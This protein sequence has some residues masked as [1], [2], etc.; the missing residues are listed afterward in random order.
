MR[1]TEP[2]IVKAAKGWHLKFTVNG[3]VKRMFFKDL[4]LNR[5]KDLGERETAFNIVREQISQELKS[6]KNQST[7]APKPTYALDNSLGDDW[8]LSYALDFALEKKREK[9][10][11]K[12]YHDYKGTIKYVQTAIV[13]LKYQKLP[14]KETTRKHI[15]FIMEQVKK[16]RQWSDYAYN[17]NLGYLQGVMSALVKW[18]IIESNPA[19]DQETYKIEKKI[20][21]TATPEQHRQIAIYLKEIDFKFYRYVLTLFHTGIRP[22][23]LCDLKLGDINM[24]KREITLKAQYTKTDAD[25]VVAISPE[26]YEHLY[27][28]DFNDFPSTFYLFGSFCSGKRAYSNV[29]T[30]APYRMA[31]SSAT[32]KWHKYV[33]TDLGIQVDLYSNKH[34]GA[35]KLRKLGVSRDAIKRNF[36]HGSMDMTDIYITEEV[37][38]D[39]IKR[40]DLRFDE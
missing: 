23:E 18:F 21:V 37:L 38:L 31:R 30:P 40:S 39:E 10:A 15:K 25:R 4:R 20:T 26:L 13:A 3:T 33:K 9:L 35:N 11:R 5:I 32:R 6:R 7:E 12:T 22:E 34:S 36:G 2:T 8:T 19:H 1:Y 16:D 29:F 17:K 14:V 24:R 28:M 27:D